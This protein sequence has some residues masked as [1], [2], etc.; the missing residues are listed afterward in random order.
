[1]DDRSHSSLSVTRSRCFGDDGAS[2]V[3]YAVLIALISVVCI[4]ALGYLGNMTSAKFSSVNDS[5]DPAPAVTATAPPATPPT[6]VHH[7]DN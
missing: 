4:A 3:E 5:L 7:D 6:T 2:I 1:M